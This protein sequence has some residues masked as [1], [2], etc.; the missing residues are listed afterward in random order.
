[1]QDTNITSMWDTLLSPKDKEKLV[2]SIVL[3]LQ[4]HL[5]LKTMTETPLDGIILN[6]LV[7][8]IPG[9]SKNK[10]FLQ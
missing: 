1:M 9:G 3:L 4:I 6:I 5:S 7:A 8:N 2:V 10:A